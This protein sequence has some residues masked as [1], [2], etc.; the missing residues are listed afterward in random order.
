[1]AGT[2]QAVPTV[3]GSPAHLTSI[4]LDERKRRLSGIL[5]AKVE[6]GYVIESQTDTEA[7]LATAGR[8]RWFGLRGHAPGS[9]QR[10]AIDEQ[11][12][13]STRKCSA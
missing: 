12:R 4:T 8:S 10:I 11:G 9:R 3:D 13:S 2:V 7:V 6:Q 1:M 5:E